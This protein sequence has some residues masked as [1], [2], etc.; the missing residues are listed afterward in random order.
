[1]KKLLLILLLIPVLSF[2]Q[3]TG[4]IGAGYLDSTPNHTVSKS[5]RYSSDTGFYYLHVDTI[6]PDP[7]VKL[8]DF[9]AYIDWCNNEGAEE[10]FKV[11][12]ISAP[13]KLPLDKTVIV[14]EGID[15]EQDDT[16]FFVL[17]V[18]I[19]RKPTF[20]GFYEWLNDKK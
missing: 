20:E 15:T 18:K 10:R 16:Y 1:M 19:P 7:V 13:S 5:L 3:T 14:R 17:K 11:R 4:T 8:S 6:K 9:K 2:A 12:V